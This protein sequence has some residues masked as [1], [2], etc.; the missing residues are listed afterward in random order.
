MSWKVSPTLEQGTLD[1]RMTV[2]L[3]GSSVLLVVGIHHHFFRSA[4]PSLPF[5]FLTPTTSRTATTAK[6]CHLHNTVMIHDEPPLLRLDCLPYDVLLHVIAHLDF[7][8]V[9]S[10]RSVRIIPVARSELH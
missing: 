7:M 5:S 8:D 1:R 3:V 4:H 10:L 6:Q 9:Q 2:L